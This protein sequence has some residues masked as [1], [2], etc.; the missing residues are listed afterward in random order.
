LIVV[1]DPVDQDGRQIA[2]SATTDT[3]VE[4]CLHLAYTVFTKS[5]L[6]KALDRVGCKP[7]RKNPVGIYNPNRLFEGMFPLINIHL[8][9]ADYGCLSWSDD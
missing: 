3:A 2:N 9:K 1:I 6:S 5:F 8:F 7:Y 4:P